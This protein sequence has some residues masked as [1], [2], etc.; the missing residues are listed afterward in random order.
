M[1]P[2]DS[3]ELQLQIQSR[4]VDELAASEKRYRELVQHLREII[5]ECDGAGKLMFLNQAWVEILGHPI[6][7]SVGRPIADFVDGQDR[8]VVL[9][10]IT[11][12]RERTAR[13]PI[14]LRFQHH[15][16][17][18]VWL[19]LS[20]RTLEDGA[21]L[22]AVQ[23]IVGSLYNVNDRKRA[24]EE[25]QKAHDL[26]EIRVEERTAALR[27]TNQLLKQEVTEREQAEAA[28]LQA[29]EA[30]EA[31]TR[32]KSEFLAKMSHELRTPMNAI[33]GFTRLVMRRCK[34][35]LPA[36][37]S[38]NLGKILISAERLL[39]LINDILDLAKVEAGRID[40]RPVTFAVEPLILECL[41]SVEPMLKSEKV[42][43]VADMSPDL[44]P[45]TTDKDRLHQ[46]LINLLSNA[47]KFTEN[48]SIKILA[49][50]R[51]EEITIAVADSGIGIPAQ[52]LERIFEEFRQVD[53]GT[54]RQYGGT[55]LGL[56]ISRHF[57][58]LLG[59]D[60]TVQ[61]RVGH[62]SIFS[63]T[64]P[65]K[66]GASQL[67]ARD[68]QSLTDDNRGTRAVPHQKTILAIDDD[69]NMVYLL[70]ENLAEAGYYVV[71]AATADEGRRKAREL[72]PFAITLD[73]L[74]PKRD[75]WQVLHELKT[76]TSMRNIPIIVLSVVDNKELAF[77]LGA[78]DCLLKPVDR[79]LLLAAL[80]RIEAFN[81]G[82]D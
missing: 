58:R 22:G 20:T 65:I 16:G 75:G 12:G 11:S 80:S 50:R 14:E 38:D 37:Q 70:R 54:T 7:D 52:A 42:Q 4:L 66:Y 3:S 63:V 68:T 19:E 72:R 8:G 6:N 77:R 26:L 21:S 79:D 30:A 5:F 56:S 55:G 46:I 64:I 61:S 73:I 15:S 23:S 41:H 82:I 57:A 43:L 60:I 67:A 76:D 17:E 32:A 18:I 10:A 81:A 53:G 45:L 9:A 69:P 48:G 59:G 51:G 1:S 27:E 44:P 74:M 13:E 35:I 62:G 25:L 39:A 40:I 71:D 78:F 2:P 31:A 24:R 28:L 33:I 36:I 49:T 47:V 34:D 29:K